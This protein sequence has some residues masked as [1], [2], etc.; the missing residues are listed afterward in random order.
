M[1]THSLGLHQ[2]G[3]FALVV[4]VVSL[5]SRFFDAPV[6]YTSIT[7]A[8]DKVDTQPRV[9][10]G[11]FQFGYF[12]NLVTGLAGFVCVVAIAPLVGPRL[13]GPDGTLLLMLFGIT[14]AMSTVDVS[15]LSLLRVLDRFDV[16]L[17][18][19]LAG[20]ASRLLLVAGALL[21]FHSL[22]AVVVALVIHDALTAAM[23]VALAARCL[24][25]RTGVSV[26][27]P[28]LSHISGLR[29]SMLGMIFHTNVVSYV[30]L[31]ETQVPAILLGA[32]SGPSEVA[33]FKVGQAAGTALA[34]LTDPV[35]QALIP[36]A[37][38]L[39]SLAEIKTLRRMLLQATCISVPVM[40]LV[41]AIAIALR[42]PILRVIAGADAQ[43]GAIVLA[44]ACLAQVVNGGLFWN[45]PLLY[46]CKKARTAA[47]IYVANLAVLIPVLVFFTSRWGANGA[48]LALLISMVGV[49]AG[50]TIAATRLLRI[51]AHQAEVAPQTQASIPEAIRGT[52]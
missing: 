13:I 27:R 25:R 50:A 40:A 5:I 47:R 34:K 22:L 23:G 6:S 48:A 4:S 1:I 35:W 9:L 36:R 33:I 38:R 31:V 17:W 46:A 49:N 52:H 29:R 37:A 39:W 43:K 8:A 26:F 21:L 30:R 20:E 16:T 12:V 42:E 7:F 2:Y 44:L 10:T 24:R 15:S 19:T 32:F 18:Y 14:L 51:D 3:V 41:G 11:V 28:V 45:V